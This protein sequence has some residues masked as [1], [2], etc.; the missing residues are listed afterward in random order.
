MTIKLEL[1]IV[2]FTTK[3]IEIGNIFLGVEL[4]FLKGGEGVIPGQLLRKAV[5]YYSIH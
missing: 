5:G 2:S 1:G 3:Y 4:Y